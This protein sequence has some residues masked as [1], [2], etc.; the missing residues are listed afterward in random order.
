MGVNLTGGTRFFAM[1]EKHK[2]RNK[3]MDPPAPPN[4]S[5]EDWSPGSIDYVPS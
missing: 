2:I 5:T 4:Q 3:R 1:M